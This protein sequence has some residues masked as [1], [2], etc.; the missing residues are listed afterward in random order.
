MCASAYQILKVISLIKL[1]VFE[2]RTVRLRGQ[3]SGL[4]DTS[5][6]HCILSGQFRDGIRTWRDKE[7]HHEG[8]LQHCNK[9]SRT[10]ET[11]LAEED[12]Y[13]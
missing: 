1:G 12:G 13:M 9:Q 10:I 7:P 6:R 5:Y 11:D 2:C 8:I 3:K 4:D